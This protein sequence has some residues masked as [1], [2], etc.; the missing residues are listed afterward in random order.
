MRVVHC[1]EEIRDKAHESLKGGTAATVRKASLAE[2]ATGASLDPW[3][4][5]VP[6]CILAWSALDNSGARAPAIFNG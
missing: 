3:H 2:T 1:H 5:H 4:P 6:A